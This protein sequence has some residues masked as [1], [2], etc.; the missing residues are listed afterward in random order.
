MISQEE[1][2]KD[3]CGSLALSYNV[4]KKTALRR[5]MLIVNDA[6]YDEVLYRDYIDH[7][8]VKAKNDLLSLNIQP[9]NDHYFIKNVFEKDFDDIIDVVNSSYSNKRITKEDLN[10]MWYDDLCHKDFWCAI[11]SKRDFITNK[12]TKEKIYKPIGMFIGT[13][14]EQI[15]EASIEIFCIK[16]E[17]RR[18]GIGFSLLKEV[19]LRIG[20]DSTYLTVLYPEKNDYNLAEMFHKVGFTGEVRWHFLKKKVQNEISD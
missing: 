17:F 6:N 16:P 15:G 18:K 20:C 8:F 9:L 14:D 10:K 12:D 3:P 19:L 4:A 7:V 11:Y 13:L 2:L 5:D 1:Y